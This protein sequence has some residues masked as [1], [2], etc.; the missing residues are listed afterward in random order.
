MEFII[1]LIN[2]TQKESKIIQIK[3]T[4]N[5]IH[6]NHIILYMIT[7]N[8]HFIINHKRLILISIVK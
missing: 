4:N 5:I 6:T 3:D 8:K 2:K 7:L 1:K